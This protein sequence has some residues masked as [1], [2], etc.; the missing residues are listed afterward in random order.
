MSRID[1]PI[2]GLLK[3]SSV[4]FMCTAIRSSLNIVIRSKL[5]FESNFSMDF[6]LVLSLTSTRF[7]IFSI[8][9]PNT[10]LFISLKKSFSKSF[11]AFVRSSVFTSMYGFNQASSLNE[12]P[13]TYGTTG[14]LLADTVVRA[15][16]ICLDLAWQRQDVR[17]LS[18][19]T[20]LCSCN[21]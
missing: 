3:T 11:V 20:D 1:I 7:R 17:L 21:N 12:T 9:F 6:S 18:W 16:L 19:E 8:V 2:T 14:E 4:F 10:E 5:G 15:F 13:R